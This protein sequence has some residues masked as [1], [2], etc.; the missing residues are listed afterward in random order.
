MADIA[1]RE[2]SD[3]ELAA[4]FRPSADHVVATLDGEPVLYVRFQTIDGRRWGL[5]NMLSVVSTITIPTMFY[6]L[7]KRLRR[8]REPVYALATNEGSARLLR[9]IGLEP[10][11]ETYI[12]KKVWVWTPEQ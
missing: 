6:A 2:P 7:R 9:L 12:G 10:T 3:A 1:L 8:E 4:V 5:I 11:A